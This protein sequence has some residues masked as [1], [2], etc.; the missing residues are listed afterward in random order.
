M[1]A[2]QPPLTAIILVHYGDVSVTAN[3]LRSLADSAGQAVVVVSNNGTSEQAAQLSAVMEALYGAVRRV[4]PGQAASPG[5][6]AVLVHNGSNRGFAAGC[7]SG[8]RIAAGMPGVDFMWLLNNDTRVEP[9]SLAALVEEAGACPSAVLGATVVRADSPDVLQVAG[10]YRYQPALTRISPNHAGL[11]RDLVES[12]PDLAMD[13]VYGASMFFSTGLLREVGL[14]DETFFLFYEELDF[15]RRAV[16]LGATLR[17]CRR[18]V[19]VHSESASIGRGRRA[20]VE[21]KKTAAYHE[22]RSTVFFS[23][24]HHPAVVPL[25]LGVRLVVKPIVLAAR[26]EARYIPQ[27]IR[28]AV[29]GFVCRRNLSTGFF[30]DL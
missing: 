20:S 24:K 30:L 16:A 14:L 10:G 12:V 26:G 4:D 25:A 9:G 5:D 23:R 17:W 11:P 21:Q 28:G 22:A 18:C 8:L 7:N 29:H 13:Y 15:C 1:P 27:A 6:R 3:C 19:V 2:A